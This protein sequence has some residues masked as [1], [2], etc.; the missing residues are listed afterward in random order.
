MW[1]TNQKII[2]ILKVGDILECFQEIAI[3][4][5]LII[6]FWSIKNAE[7]KIASLHVSNVLISL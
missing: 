3:K 2:M 1:F 4:K 7:G 5:S 6:L